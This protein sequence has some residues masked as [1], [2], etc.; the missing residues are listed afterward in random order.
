[1]EGTGRDSSASAFSHCALSIVEI[2]VIH[3]YDSLAQPTNNEGV[4]II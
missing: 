4:I 1:M 2:T 3:Y